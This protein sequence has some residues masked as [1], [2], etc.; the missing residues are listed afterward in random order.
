MAPV[1]TATS[2]F[3]T[4]GTGE[5]TY[6]V[7]ID[8]LRAFAVFLVFVF[9]WWPLSSVFN[10]LPNGLIGVTLFFVLSG[11]LITRILI[12]ARARAEETGASRLRVCRQFFLRRALR[13]FPI[14]Y[15]TLVALW[16]VP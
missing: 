11:F 3:R 14:Y 8:A 9:H 6:V 15:L 7:Q 2:A 5:T 16:L 13:I 12:N 10:I 4:Q 1:Q